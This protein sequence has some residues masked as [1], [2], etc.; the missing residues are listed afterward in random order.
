MIGNGRQ[1]RNGS[2]KFEP[3]LP[4][5]DL[6]AAI[7]REEVRLAALVAVINIHIDA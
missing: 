4:P 1:L 6:V 7:A 5:E 3:A 2:S